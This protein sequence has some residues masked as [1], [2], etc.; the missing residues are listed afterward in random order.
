MQS[1]GPT[2]VGCIITKH[3]LYDYT[4]IVKEWTWIFK[5]K[6][7]LL[8]FSVYMQLQLDQPVRVVF[9]CYWAVLHCLKAKSME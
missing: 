3:S 6:V 2:V 8:L 1:R 7:C 4:V 9:K 5:S